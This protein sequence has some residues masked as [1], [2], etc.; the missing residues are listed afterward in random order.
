[1]GLLLE[2]VKKSYREPGGG[3]LPVLDIERF[4]VASGEQVVLVGAS[5]GGKTTLLNVISGITSPDSG[6]VVINGI[7]ITKLHEVGRDRF[8]AANIGFVFQTFNLLPAFTALENVILGA[9]F[10]SRPIG[11]TEATKL[12][13]QVGLGHRLNHRPA[14]LSVGEQ[15]RVAVARAI[16]NQPVLLLADEPTANVDLANQES[17]L[18]LIRN[19]CSE[20]NI[21]L[22]LVTHSLEIASQFERVEKLS[23]FNRQGA[24]V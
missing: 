7:D 21:S 11:K 1:M 10:S 13:E 18:S 12:L 5:G 14:K 2:N 16:A 9:K 23:E 20:H 4:E 3:V 17:V 15:Q 8:R 24:A 6:R 19:S 22:L